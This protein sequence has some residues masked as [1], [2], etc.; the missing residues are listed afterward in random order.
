LT[1]PKLSP[2]SQ[3]QITPATIGETSHGRKKM[4]RA[5]V[6]PF[7]PTAVSATAMASDRAYPTGTDTAAYRSVRRSEP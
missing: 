6:L 7:E 1:K 2:N 3:R 4:M 5:P